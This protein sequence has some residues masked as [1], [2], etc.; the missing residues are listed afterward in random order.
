MQYLKIKCG[1]GGWR[2][3]RE[4]KELLLQVLK[5][6][7]DRCTININ[8]SLLKSISPVLSSTLKIKKKRR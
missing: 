2:G 5:H 1:V 8:N 4:G 6:D 7:Y 3:G